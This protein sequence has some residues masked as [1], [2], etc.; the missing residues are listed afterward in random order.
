MKHVLFI[1]LALCFFAVAL[2]RTLVLG[3]SEEQ[4]MDQEDA[5]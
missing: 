3:Q 5:A 2:F 4:Q 1:P